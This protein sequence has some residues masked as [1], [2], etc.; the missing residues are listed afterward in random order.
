[1]ANHS[2]H[3][4]RASSFPLARFT[5]ALFVVVACAPG[6]GPE[7][8]CPK[9][10]Q[11]ACEPVAHDAGAI[12]ARPVGWA[13]G[14]DSRSTRDQRV[15]SRA[16]FATAGCPY[17]PH[18]LPRCP[19]DAKA[20]PNWWDRE[21]GS[22][23]VIAPGRLDTLPGSTTQARCGVTR[24]CCN[25]ERA[26]LVVRTRLGRIKLVSSSNPFAFQCVGDQSADCC[27]FAPGETVLVKGL[28]AATFDYVNYTMTDPELCVTEQ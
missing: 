13:S 26:Q 15:T 25:T 20:D 7:A 16:C 10:A 19:A 4:A 27:P 14:S 24:E 23:V 18:P 2:P 8:N 5:G 22:S 21:Q 9:P 6:G 11:P 12:R 17:A 3:H 1:M 28:T